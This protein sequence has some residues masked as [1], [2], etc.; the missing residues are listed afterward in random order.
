MRGRNL[1]S[2][3]VMNIEASH[4]ISRVSA[5]QRL[6]DVPVAS[7]TT[8]ASAT[9]RNGLRRARQTPRAHHIQGPRPRR[10]RYPDHSARQESVPRPCW[11]SQLRMQLLASVAAVSD[12]QR[13]LCY[14]FAL[15]QVFCLRTISIALLDGEND[16]FLIKGDVKAYRRSQYGGTTK[17][18]NNASGFLSEPLENFSFILV[19]TTHDLTRALQRGQS[20]SHDAPVSG[21]KG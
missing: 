8:Q 19:R 3:A 17:R 7:R 18:C 21:Y 13:E 10:P 9:A 16:W 5:P 12:D 2:Y 20:H 6:L 1:Y 4:D 11:A 15:S 14:I